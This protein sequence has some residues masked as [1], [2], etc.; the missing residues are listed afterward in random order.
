MVDRRSFS[1]KKRA[2]ICLRQSG[3]CGCGEKL[4][5]GRYEIDHIAALIHGGSNDDDNLRAICLDCHKAKTRKDVQGR[6][7]HDRIAAGGK[8]RKG[9]PM[10]G[11]RDSGLKKHMD[12]TVSRRD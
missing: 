2:E 1:F 4:Q 8:Q 3:K 9:P 6:A 11:S 5:P 12:G 7:H 10:P